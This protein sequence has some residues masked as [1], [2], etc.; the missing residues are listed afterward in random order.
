MNYMMI[1]TETTNSLDDPLVYDVGYEVFDESGATIET[2][3]M[4]NK[5]IFLDADFMATAFYADKIPN[6]WKEIWAKKRELLS[7]CEIKWKV[8]D[9]CKRNGCTIVA[10]HNARF[11]RMALNLTQRYITTSRYRFFLPYGTTWWC[12]LRM[13]KEILKDNQEY[14]N[15][16]KYFGYWANNN[17][18][19]YTAEILYQ[20]ISG[21]VYFE[22]KHQG[23]D[24]VKIEKEIFLW[25]LAQKPDI[26][27]RLFKPKEEPKPPPEPWE[28][29]LAAL[30][31][32]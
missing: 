26:D 12:S 5:D 23:I 25:C 20:F 32:D 31:A 9:A 28:I 17:Q 19:R 2:A 30:L 22:E 14:R 15:F 7:W 8:F 6:Y 3:S 18:P 10:A 16:C 13:A 4:T 1:D 29:E 21:D 11:D 24:D 27:G